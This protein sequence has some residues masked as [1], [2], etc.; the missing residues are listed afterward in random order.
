MKSVSN[1]L[2]MKHLVL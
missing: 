1:G 2:V